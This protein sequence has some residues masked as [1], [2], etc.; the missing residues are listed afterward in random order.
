[1]F[2]QLLMNNTA[3]TKF[4]SIYGEHREVILTNSCSESEPVDT[5]FRGFNV[6]SSMK[7]DY[8]RLGTD[9]CLN[10]PQ[11]AGGDNATV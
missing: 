11:G 6:I 3:P 1:M 8:K 10:T 5:K 9:N 4:L 7:T 2:D